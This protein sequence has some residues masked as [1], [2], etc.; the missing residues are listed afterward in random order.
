[1]YLQTPSGKAPKGTVKVINSNGRLQLRFRYGGK[2][3]YLSMG[4]PNSPTNQIA[5]QRKAEVIYLDIVS[6]NFDPSLQK[7]KPQPVKSDIPKETTVTA[8]LSVQELLG[9]YVEYKASSWKETTLG[10][11]ENLARQLSK[12]P[13]LPFSDALKVKA[14]LQNVTTLD[15]TRRILIQLNAAGRWAL[16]HKLVDGNPYEGMAAEMPKP[17]YQ[18][19]PNPNAFTEEER[20][21]IIETFKAHQGNWNGRGFTGFAY[22]HYAPFVEFLFLTGCRPSEAV[23]LRWKNVAEDC[24]SI[25]FV[26]AITLAGTGRPIRV[27]GSK[28]NRTRLF[29]CSPRL[30]QLLRSIKTDDIKPDALVF[31]SPKGKAINYQNFANN[32]WKRIVDPIRTG[33][34]PYSCRDTFITIQILKRIP[35]SVIAQ[36]CDT[37]VAMIQRNYADFLKMQSLRPQD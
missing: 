3:Y 28:N 20:D 5:A 10:D 11:R 37:S 32:A 26:E 27:Q 18:L 19:N 17:N 35:E 2:R 31:P 22:S 7:Y 30:A 13:P 34:T 29:P 15:Q 4:L 12:I 9:K 25:H 6:G 16:K 33:T 23:G 14:E 24:Q 21:R 36:W 1:M 8:V